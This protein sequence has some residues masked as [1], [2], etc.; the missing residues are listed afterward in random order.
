MSAVNNARLLSYIERIERLE[1]EKRSVADDIKDVKAEAKSAGFDVKMITKMISLRRMTPAERRQEKELSEIYEAACGLLDGTPLG[2]AA[3]ERL[4]KEEPNAEPEPAPPAHAQEVMRTVEEARDEGREAFRAGVRIIDNPYTAGDPRRAAWD[5][6][7][8]AASGSDGMDIPEAWRRKAKKGGKG[9]DKRDGGA[10]AEASA[11][12]ES[13][14]DPDQDPLPFGDPQDPADPADPDDHPGAFED[15]APDAPWEA[16]NADPAPQ[17]EGDAAKR[18]DDLVKRTK[19]RQAD[20]AAEKAAAKSAPKGATKRGAKAPA[21]P[22][23]ANGE[24]QP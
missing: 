2:D 5:E 4:M 11:A 20:T 19:R 1:E 3:R 22:R 14:V 15:P 24:G 17:P 7:F 9:D 23:K 10:T 21:K 16:P 18:L 12:P 8:C 13:A 6:G